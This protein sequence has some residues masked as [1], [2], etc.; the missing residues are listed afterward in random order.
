M[1]THAL[2]E[3]EAQLNVICAILVHHE[4]IAVAILRAARRSTC[5]PIISARL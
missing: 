3:F 1:Q 4:R 5:R 2:T